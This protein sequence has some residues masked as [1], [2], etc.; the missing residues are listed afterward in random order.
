[1]RI[2]KDSEGNVTRIEENARQLKKSKEIFKRKPKNF[3]QN[4]EKLP[5]DPNHS[6]F[7]CSITD[8]RGGGKAKKQARVKEETSVR[9]VR[10]SRQ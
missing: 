2:E 9:H 4:K 6:T 10:S 7:V 8:I 1:V 5:N 3:P